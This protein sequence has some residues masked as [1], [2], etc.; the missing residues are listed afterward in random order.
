MYKQLTIVG[1][2]LCL[3]LTAAAQPVVVDPALLQQMQK[4]IRQQQ[5]QLQQQA[6]QIKAQAE[7]LQRL[8]QQ[9]SALQQAAPLPP[10]TIPVTVQTTQPPPLITSGND[11]IKLAISGQINRAVVVA[12]DGYN[13]TLYHVDNTVSNSRFRLVGTARATEDLSI[14]T[15]IEIAVSPDRSSAV[16][17]K[18]K[19]IGDLFDQRWVEISLASKTFGKLSIGKG[20]TAS[21]TTAEVDLS[22]TDV[23]QYASISDMGGGFLFR[24]KNG[25]KSFI[26]TSKDASGKPVYLKISDAFNSFDGLSRQ[27][28]L[29]YD[30]PNLYG[31]SLAGSLVSN[32][33]SD[34]ALFWGGEGYGFKGAGA[35]AV[36]NPKLANA[37]LLYDGSFSLLHST[38]G[39]NLTLSGA[40]QQYT[41]RKDA[42]NLYAKLGWLATFTNL[43]YT[44]FGVDYA[45]S[46]HLAQS[47]DKGYSVGAAVVQAFEKYATELYLQYRVF[48]LDRASGT[49]PVADINIGTFGARVKF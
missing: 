10:Q 12:N 2:L 25:T 28:R 3:P 4:T 44:A 22:K 17:Q 49:T 15:R 34:L 19:T 6:E 48:S 40:L 47:G 35:F 18:D 24:S 45:R 39:L 27:S 9:I 31:F 41:S 36:S 13:S 16:S 8:Q 30:S 33:R 20:D 46:E 29:R 1:L 23:V 11:K 38:S 42:T 32:Q 26:E 5:Q 21:N 14:G 37:G 7:V 43:G